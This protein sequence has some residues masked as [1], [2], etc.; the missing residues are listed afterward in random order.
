LFLTV[1]ETV[2]ITAGHVDVSLLYVF[3]ADSSDKY[4][5]DQTEF[6]KIWWFRFNELPLD[7]TDPHLERFCSKLF[8]LLDVQTESSSLAGEQNR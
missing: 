1:T 3:L 8:Q 4:S 5:Y 7:R 6:N 2:G